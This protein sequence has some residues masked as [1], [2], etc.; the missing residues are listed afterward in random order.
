[1]LTLSYQTKVIRLQTVPGEYLT[2][3]QQ[4]RID[5]LFG[6]RAIIRSFDQPYHVWLTDGSAKIRHNFS[7][8]HS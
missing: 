7:P 8:A 3:T 5:A 2:K 4:R 6:Y 1:M